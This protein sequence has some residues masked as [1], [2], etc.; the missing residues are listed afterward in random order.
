MLGVSFLGI[1]K[2]R[3]IN[4]FLA[5]YTDLNNLN[6]LHL[7]L[8]K[9]LKEKCT[10]NSLLL[11]SVGLAFSPFPEVGL[12]GQLS[13]PWKKMCHCH[14]RRDFVAFFCSSIFTQGNVHPR[15]DLGFISVVVVWQ[16]NLF[17]FTLIVE[18]VLK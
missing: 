3:T 12:K 2:I 14:G 1:K 17:E 7:L 11:L 4:N 10:I 13:N 6:I 16:Q 8:H 18:M 15:V 9:T 5:I